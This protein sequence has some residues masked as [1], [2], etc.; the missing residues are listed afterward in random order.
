MSSASEDHPPPFCA[1]VLAG[2]SASRFGSDKLAVA[3]GGVSLLDRVLGAVRAARTVIAVGESRTMDVDVTWVRE[4]PA[5]SGPAS[6]IATALPLVSTPHVVV[7]AGDLPFVDAHTVGRLLAAATPA[8]ALVD[9]RGRVQYLCSA[10]E[11][12]VLRDAA[13]TTDWADRSVRE[14]LAPLQL[15]PVRA[16]GREAHDVDVPEDVPS[17][18]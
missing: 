1:V 12:A 10:F 16:V 8:A 5:L 15:H 9:P 4:R 2:G 6:A 7:L 17:D 13:G 11:T 18:P 14:L 3:V